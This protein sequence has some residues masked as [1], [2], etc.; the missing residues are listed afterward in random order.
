M[1]DAFSSPVVESYDNVLPRMTVLAARGAASFSGAQLTA[2]SGVSRIAIHEVASR[3]SNRE[4]GAM[5]RDAEILGI[6]RRAT[7]NIDEGLLA[8]MPRLC[9]IAVYSSGYEWIEL[10]A[11]GRRGITL[12]I[13]P[14]YSTKTVAEHTWGMILTMSRRLH[15]S[16]RIARGDLPGGISL[17]GWELAGKRL[18]IIGLGRIGKAVAAIAG[19]FSM[20]VIYYDRRDVSVN[21]GSALSFDEVLASADVLVV[22]SS[23]DRGTAPIIDSSAIA[24]MKQGAYLVNPARPSLVNNDEV[25]KAIREKRLAGYAVDERVYSRGQLAGIE[26]GR[27]FQTGHTAWYSNEAME[28]GTQ[29]WVDNLVAL[30]AGRPINLVA[31]S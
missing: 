2:L 26:H 7:T 3:L 19:A 23:Y 18:G 9:G 25:L 29:C 17:R 8:D 14:D 21:M 12:S 6:T 15:L 22:A 28:R 10:E 27:I 4:L 1:K 30:A 16:D 13:L 11:L 20:D 24:Q 31:G 5:C